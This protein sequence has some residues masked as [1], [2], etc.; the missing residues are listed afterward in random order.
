M[1]RLTYKNLDAVPTWK[2]K[3][4]LEHPHCQGIDG[5]DYEPVKHELLS[6]YWHRCNSEAEKQFKQFERE[7]K[8]YFKHCATAH[9]RTK[10]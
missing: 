1:S 5:A 7:Q 2:L 4:I 6:D 9:K 3:E 10:K 8:Q